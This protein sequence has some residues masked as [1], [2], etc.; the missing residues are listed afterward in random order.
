VDSRAKVEYNAYVT[1]QLLQV[2]EQLE[3]Y[4]AN[5]SVGAYCLAAL[6]SRFGW[7][8]RSRRKPPMHMD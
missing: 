3:E 7:V 6:R 5:H 2:R 1:D 4:I 8:T